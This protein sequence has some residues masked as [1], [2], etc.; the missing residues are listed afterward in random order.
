M[1]TTSKENALMSLLDKI[2]Q[3][4]Y[5]V[6]LMSLKNDNPVYKIPKNIKTINAPFKFNIDANE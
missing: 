3:D 6:F 5:D 2:P 4:R 1:P